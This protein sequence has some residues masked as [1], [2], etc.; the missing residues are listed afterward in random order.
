MHMKATIAL[1]INFLLL[2][3]ES[4]SCMLSIT[5]GPN[6]PCLCLTCLYHIV[7]VVCAGEFINGDLSLVLAR[8]SRTHSFQVWASC[9]GLRRAKT[10]GALVPGIGSGVS[11][12][13][14]CSKVRGCWR[15]W[16]VTSPTHHTSHKTHHTPSQHVTQNTETKAR[17]NSHT[18]AAQIWRMVNIYFLILVIYNTLSIHVI[19][20]WPSFSATSY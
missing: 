16:L 17:N 7:T 10:R 5:R 19:W 9:G 12:A 11:P 4:S 1:Q 13:D 8:W 20:D 2:L 18:R 3:S 14:D 15:D 6:N